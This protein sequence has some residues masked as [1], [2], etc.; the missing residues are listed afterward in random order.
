[1]VEID[2]TVNQVENLTIHSI[3]ILGD[4]FKQ[5][6]LK[7]ASYRSGG[8]YYPA[9]NASELAT[10]IQQAVYE[11][12][13]VTSLN[14]DVGHLATFYLG[15]SAQLMDPNVSVTG[16]NENVRTATIQISENFDA[17]HDRLY[18]GNTPSDSGTIGAL[19]WWYEA[20]TGTLQ[21]VGI[22]TPQAYQDVMRQIQYTN[23]ALDPAN[24]NMNNRTL[25]VSIT[26][27]ITNNID[28][29]NLSG[30]TFVE[31]LHIDGPEYGDAPAS[32]GEAGQRGSMR[33]R[34][35]DLVDTEAA[36]LFSADAT[37]DNLDNS[38]DEDG[39]SITGLPLLRGAVGE[40]NVNVT[41][42]LNEQA[43]VQIWPISTRTASLIPMIRSPET[44]LSSLPIVGH[45]PI[46]SP[47]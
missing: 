31:L 7:Y 21:I 14:L 38:N 18:I 16:E 43:Y 36:Q 10:S 47:L 2:A 11:G 35:G 33:L 9:T 20:A 34:L 1:M 40:A 17:T 25:D 12:D 13:C 46:Q 41:N 15:G 8:D 42:N 3:A 24:T 19:T 29:G 32:Y 44:A 23:S 30:Q 6:I 45:R 28:N 37:G 26:S 4:N 5:D 39:V 22:D 27:E